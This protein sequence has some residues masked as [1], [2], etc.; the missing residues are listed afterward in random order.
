MT[1]R[2]SAAKYRCE[3]KAKPSNTRS[4]AAT[5][6]VTLHVEAKKLGANLGLKTANQ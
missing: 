4:M 6:T 5:G 1:S 2:P 3:T